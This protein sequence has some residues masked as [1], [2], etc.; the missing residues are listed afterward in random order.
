MHTVDWHSCLT[1]H[2]RSTSDSSSSS[3]CSNGSA[4]APSDSS[5]GRSNGTAHDASDGYADGH[6][7]GT[8]AHGTKQGGTVYAH[9]LSNGAG[10]VRGCFGAVSVALKWPF[11]GIVCA[12]QKDDGR[13]LCLPQQSSFFV[14]IMVPWVMH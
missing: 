4:H 8:A 2:S 11:R 5:T 14:W 12:K 13:A 1:T 6:A 7:Q 9:I 3:T 10:S